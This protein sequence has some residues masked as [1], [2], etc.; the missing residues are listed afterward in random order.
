MSWSPRGA[1]SAFVIA[2]LLAQLLNYLR[3]DPRG[4]LVRDV[5]SPERIDEVTVVVSNAF[6]R[7]P[8]HE[9]F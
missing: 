7:A 2:L 4:R 1:I 5:L 8:Y 9:R 6:H 3:N